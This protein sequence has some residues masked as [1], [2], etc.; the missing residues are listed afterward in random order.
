MG[1]GVS[2]SVGRVGTINA[3]EW[4][5]M[6]APTNRG[7]VEG[8]AVTAGAGTRQ[9]TVAS[10]RVW[11]ANSYHN[12]SG[13]TLSLPENTSGQ[14]RQ[15]IVA[16][17]FDWATD[18][19]L[20]SVQGTPAASPTDPVASLASTAGSSWHVPLAAVLVS[21]GASVLS[22]GSVFDRRPGPWQER[23]PVSP[24]SNLGGGAAT[25]AIRKDPLGDVH[26]RGA[27][28]TTSAIS[29][30]EAQPFITLP[31][32]WRPALRENFVVT[33]RDND[34]NPA[35]SGRV[36]IAPTGEVYVARPRTTTGTRWYS[37]SGIY[38][39]PAT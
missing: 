7:Y 8:C 24:W 11:V 36:V 39:T 1:T 3:A 31:A 21:S 22:A 12:V 15:D 26:L 10:G 18:A 29:S 4:G 2:A 16:L 32:Q 6:M 38:V 34:L 23:T 19:S 25:F 20:V 30:P 27:V 33:G 28:A 9:V 35:E 37:L 5:I 17:H 14:P 13:A